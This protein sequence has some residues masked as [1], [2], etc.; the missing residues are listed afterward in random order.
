MNLFLIRVEKEL[1]EKEAI[2]KKV[3]KL[4]LV[5]NDELSFYFDYDSYKDKLV[6]FLNNI[7]KNKEIKE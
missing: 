2:D 6:E 7:V 1:L 4:A 5:D 3:L